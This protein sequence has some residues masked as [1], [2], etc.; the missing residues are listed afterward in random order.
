MLLPLCGCNSKKTADAAG[1]CTSFCE[2]VKAGDTDKLMTY[3]GDAEITSK[4]LKEIISP[5]G[6]NSEEKAVSDCIR[7]TINYKVQ[8]PVY[9]YKAR[10]ATV[11]LSWEEADYAC[12]E[13]SA[14]ASTAEL[15]N[16]ISK[17]PVKIIT[18][19]VTVDLSGE[20]PKILNP[21]DVIDAVYAFN[22]ADYG[23]MPGLL[24]DFY[25]SG[26]WI[27]AVNNSYTNPKEIGV[28]LTFKKDLSKYKM[29]P[30]IKYTVAK[31]DKVLV[32]SEIVHP[33]NNSL[34]ISYTSEM[35]DP[36]G[37]NA[38]GFLN[39]GKYT[40]KVTDEYSNDIAS[41]DC[42]VKYEELEKEEIEFEEY[43]DDEYLDDLIYEFKDDE[44]KGK[45]IVNKSGWWD[46]DGTSVG[47]SAFG[48]DTT[49]L[50]FSLAVN[51]ENDAELYF[52]Y[53]YSEEA[54]FGDLSEAEPVYQ[55]SCKPSLYIDQ[56][57]YDFDYSSGE[58][59]P[60]YYGLVVYGDAAKKHIVLV[61]SCMVVEE[62]SE[63][64]LA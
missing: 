14:A 37:L 50:G 59:K 23:I 62:T 13:A 31:G 48:S 53:Y 60:G 21:K 33:E 19:C 3:F 51:P 55:R 46:Y 29:V 6:F 34:K 40:V 12:E 32:A 56:A 49:I 42:E 28:R 52:E 22:S 24:S 4:E 35:S 11:Y 8:E 63:E 64:V 57:C 20:V 1:I 61:A 45:S 36:A 5:S 7:K 9:D 47:N 43:T 17:A 41:F 18:S 15:R 27:K 44:L 38:D 58:L 26:D 25:S 39:E 30:G 10:T 16:A 54:D 2:D